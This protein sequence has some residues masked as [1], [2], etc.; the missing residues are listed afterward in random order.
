MRAELIGHRGYQ[1]LDR[2]VRFGWLHDFQPA[3]SLAANL[4]RAGKIW[5]QAIGQHAA[6]LR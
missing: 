6:S 1:L 4:Q 2:F 5:R 3:D